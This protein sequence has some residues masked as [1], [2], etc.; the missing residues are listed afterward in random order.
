[1]HITWSGKNKGLDGSRI[2][3]LMFR[4]A[5]RILHVVD[6]RRGASVDSNS[7]SWGCADAPL[8]LAGGKASAIKLTV[9]PYSVKI[10]INRV[11]VCQDSWPTADRRAYDGAKVYL[12]DPWYAP[13]VAQVNN[14]YL[15]RGVCG[16]NSA[17]TPCRACMGGR[18]SNTTGDSGACTHQ[19]P[20]GSYATDFK[21]WKPG[22]NFE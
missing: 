10:F 14:L 2:P 1:M 15:V 18:F 3:A 6:G 22:L 16:T 8:T 21:P 13:A 12:A 4:P 9:T 11:L 20:A 5:T 17:S 7:V 19:C